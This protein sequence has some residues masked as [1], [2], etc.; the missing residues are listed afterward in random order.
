M[1]LYRV[2]TIVKNDPKFKRTVYAFA[3]TKE[4][5][6]TFSGAVEGDKV[7]VSE[8]GES[9]YPYEAAVAWKQRG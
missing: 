4:R 3:K 9:G 7:L 6:K 8:L 1:K 5:A 2:T